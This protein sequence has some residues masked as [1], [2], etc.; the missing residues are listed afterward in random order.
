MKVSW[1]IFA[2]VPQYRIL[3]DF[4][5]YHYY[6]LNWGSQCSATENFSNLSKVKFPS[7]H[8][9]HK[10]IAYNLFKSYT[11]KVQN[12][13]ICLFALRKKV[14]NLSLLLQFSNTS[15]C[16]EI[17]CEWQFS[18]S[19]YFLLPAGNMYLDTISVFSANTVRNTYLGQY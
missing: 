12:Q 7:L 13:I 4:G 16:T 5:Q 19:I 3:F 1:N 11:C 9:L 6:E 14:E 10:F 15:I 17:S 18:C 8:L 2:I